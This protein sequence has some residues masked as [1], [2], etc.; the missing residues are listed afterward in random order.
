MRAIVIYESMYGNTRQIAE[1]IAEGLSGAADVEVVPI[2]KLTPDQLPGAGL[3]VVGGPTHMLGL[4]GP[5]S[6]R[7]AVSAASKPGSGL[8]VEE[9]AD[10]P[11]LREW[12]TKT[13][14]RGA[15]VAFDTR[16]HAKLGGRASVR[17]G[18]RLRRSGYDVIARPQSF[19]VTK[20]NTL[21][22]GETAR[23]RD[24]GSSLLRT[25]DAGTGAARGH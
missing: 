18:R 9:G 1:A 19:Y 22:P 24:W 3:I 10:G 20:A 16:L 12:L 7:M 17:I 6:R 23:A 4:S 25:V 11:G 21:E 15:A 5:G 2:T 13:R 14:G 8:S